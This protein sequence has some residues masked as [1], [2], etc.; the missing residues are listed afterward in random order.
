MHVSA[1][2]SSR[3]P[4]VW[5]V[6]NFLVKH[7]NTRTLNH[8]SE[9]IWSENY[10]TQQ[11]AIHVW[12]ALPNFTVWSQFSELGLEAK[13][14]RKWWSSGVQLSLFISIHEKM[15]PKPFKVRK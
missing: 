5:L 7:L 6:G 15:F 8:V 9:T 11:E 14:K 3:L 10:A 2:E 4:H 12:S 13:K 1:C